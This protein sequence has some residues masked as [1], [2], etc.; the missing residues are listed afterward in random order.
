MGARYRKSAYD[1]TMK[2]RDIVRRRDIVSEGSTCSA[3]R[4]ISGPAR[5]IVRVLLTYNSVNRTTKSRNLAISR[6]PPSLSHKPTIGN[7]V[8]VSPAS[9]R[10][11]NVIYFAGR[12][13]GLP[14]SGPTR[15]ARP[16]S[17]QRLETR[18]RAGAPG[19]TARRPGRAAS[20]AHCRER[21]NVCPVSRCVNCKNRPKC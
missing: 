19:E 21:T 5:D 14:P 4:T 2:T 12:T 16:G 20:L 10:A 18:A 13:S 17:R 8:K 15:E 7:G 6:P 11:G 9:L 3:R 1:S